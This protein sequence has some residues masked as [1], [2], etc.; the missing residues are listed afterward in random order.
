MTITSEER[1]ALRE[2]TAAIEQN[3]G[4]GHMI[5]THVDTITTGAQLDELSGGGETALHSH[6]EGG[7][8]DDYAAISDNDEATDVIGAELEELT[9]GSET[10]LHS[11]ASVGGG[12]SYVDRG[13]PSVYDFN[14]GG[15]LRD[16]TWRELDLSAIVPISAIRVCIG[17]ATNSN[18][19]NGYCSFRK[20]GNTNTYNVLQQYQNIA[21]QSF[22]LQGFVDLNGEDAII[23]FNF[24]DVYYNTAQVTVLGWWV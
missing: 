4:G 12:H 9:D 7:T 16:G 24:P 19:A 20:K 8:V 10:A 23:E 1:A 11:H 6:A 17:V 2:I 21:A 22:F 13:D 5:A 15:A 14:I 18:A 3:T